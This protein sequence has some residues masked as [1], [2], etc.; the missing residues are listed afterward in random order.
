MDGKSLSIFD[1][2][3]QDETPEVEAQDSPVEEVTEDIPAEAEAPPAEDTGAEEATPPVAEVKEE[4]P[5]APIAAMLDEREKRQKAERE[6][7]LMQQRL[8]RFEAQQ[9]QQPPPDW[10]DDPVKA[11]NH[12]QNLVMQHLYDQK[13][14]QSR[15]FAEREFGAEIVAEAHA[16]FEQNPQQSHQFADHPSP[17]HSAVEFYKR[18]KVI[19]EMGSDPDAWMKAQR[20]E[21]EAQIRQELQAPTPKPA[22]QTPPQSL[23]QAPAGSNPNND[24]AVKA[25]PMLNGLFNG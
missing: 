7:E 16:Y 3:I 12:Q 15:F 2:E 22:P 4:Q 11:A 19:N 14:N 8:S 25:P 13:L 24:V 18:Q 10:F 17:F 20:A 6:L 21:I 9:Q 23:S 5:M 1:D